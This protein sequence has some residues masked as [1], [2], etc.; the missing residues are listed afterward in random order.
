MSEWAIKVEGL[1][2]KYNLVHRGRNQDDT[3]LRAL[4]SGISGMFRGDRKK[5]REE[6]WALRDIDFTVKPGD[7]IGVIG[8]NGAGK[9]TMLKIMSRVV[10]PTTGRIEYNGRMASL[11]EVGTGFHGDLTGRENIY[12][13][14]SIL[15]MT[16]NEIDRNFDRIVDFSEIEQFLD[17]PV[18][19]YSSGMY[20]RLAFAV[21]A[22]LSP[23]ILVL[24]EVLAVGD[25]AFQKKCIDKMQE[26]STRE[27]R[28]LL[29][30]SH[31]MAS[32]RSLCNGALF[33]DRGRM[34]GFGSVDEMARLYQHVV[35]ESFASDVNVQV[36][37]LHTTGE[38]VVGS[39]LEVRIEW[40][41]GRF[42]KGWHCDIAAYT[43]DNVKVFAL[44]S[45]LFNG[46]AT[47]DDHARGVV[48]KVR[49]IG[50]V[51]QELRLDIGVRRHI[52]EPYEFV[53]ENCATLLPSSRNF[54]EYART[55]VVTV[56]YS[57]CA[58][59]V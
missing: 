59:I 31:N 12:L 32:V 52:D 7:R 38:W 45:H 9:S 22:H 33:L 40:T 44:Q 23:D 36:I 21:A 10:K 28:T 5:E 41:A 42:T 51:S 14:G 37:P 53:L 3:L 27:G 46:F 48:F 30:V 49:N 34:G 50:F 25:A 1:G 35:K 54:Y 20:V 24:D 47:S 15:G 57:T 6:F 55:D 11:L 17:T 8:R 43:F 2:K 13:N 18:K 26:L 39:D 29:F 4:T 56:P 19:R 58:P 16:K